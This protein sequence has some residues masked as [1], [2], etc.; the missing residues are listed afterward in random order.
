[1]LETK[2]CFGFI[3][4]EESST[5]DTCINKGENLLLKQRQNRGGKRLVF[6]SRHSLDIVYSSHF[7]T[8]VRVWKVA[9]NPEKE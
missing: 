6:H 4:K 1:M 7:A 3:E 5:T 2:R 8:A 9:I